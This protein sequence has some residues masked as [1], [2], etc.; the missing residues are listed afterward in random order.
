M[1]LNYSITS[2]IALIWMTDVIRMSPTNNPL[3]YRQLGLYNTYLGDKAFAPL[4]IKHIT[5]C[6]DTK[7]LRKA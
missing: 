7:K 6:Y 1:L 3:S 4:D 5:D 2:E